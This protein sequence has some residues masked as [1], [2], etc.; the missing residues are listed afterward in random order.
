MN[1]SG[2]APPGQLWDVGTHKMHLYSLG[3]GTPT[4][5]LDAGS[6]DS[7]LTWQPIQAEIA[8]FTRVV[9]YDRSG[10]GWS[11][12]GPNPVTPE[13]VARELHQLLIVADIQLPII[14]VGHSLG[15]VYVRAFAHWYPDDVIGLILVDSSHESQAARFAE[16][17]PHYL[18]V[19][20]NYVTLLKE[21]SGKSHQDILDH[22]FAGE[23]T[24][25]PI[26]ETEALQ[27]DRLRP[28]QLATVAE[29][30]DYAYA[31]GLKQPTDAIPALGDLRLTVLTATRTIQSPDLSA[32]EGRTM[33]RVFQGLQTEISQRSTRGQQTFVPDAGHYIHK[34]QPQVVIDAVRAL[35][36][37]VRAELP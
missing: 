24:D 23:T 6:G 7:L 14:L 9:A 8:Q 3:E 32:E 17:V 20:A 27:R 18:Q 19:S 36:E 30:L 1:D 33:S 11:E 10:M 28:T 4:V 29:E 35:V 16:T 13:N 34:D 26:A 25:T 12:R 21:L 31:V 2:F 37:A 5:V 15:G 22:F